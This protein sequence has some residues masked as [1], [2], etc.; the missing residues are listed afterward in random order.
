MAFI[1]LGQLGVS[2]DFVIN[3][4]LVLAFMLLRRGVDAYTN[5]KTAWWEYVFLA[6]CVTFVELLRLLL[7]D[8]EGLRLSII[9]IAVL[10]PLG[11]LAQRM[12]SWVARHT[13]LSPGV[14]LII[15]APVLLT[16]GLFALRPLLVVIG[17]D[18]S[19]VDFEGTSPFAIASSL[20]FLLLL[21]AFNFSL[22]SLVLGALFERLRR[23]SATDQLTGL[24]NRRVMMHRLE[25]EHARYLRSGQ[26]YAIVM[27]DLDN[28]KRVN[29][30][31]GHGVGDEV[32]R[33]LARMLK[34]SQRRTDTLARVGGEEF[35]LLM[36]MTDTDGALVQARRFCS[37]VAE[38]KVMTKGGELQLTLSLGVAEVLAGDTSAD[39]VVTRADTA[40]YRA[41]ALGRNRVEFAERPALPA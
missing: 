15:I 9:T 7:P 23:L 37:R 40:L 36:P 14:M 24:A 21:G 8:Q 1:D 5:S 22:A 16:M 19:Q 20:V 6:L 25:E 4:L 11:T 27:M 13:K 30:V 17:A 10:W 3:A 35:M 34:E 2:H 29:D 32:L 38:T 41:K 28:F 33:E 18:S 39:V 26:V 12:Y 31:Y